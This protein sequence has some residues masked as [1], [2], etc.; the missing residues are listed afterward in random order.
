MFCFGTSWVLLAVL[1]KMGRLTW[2]GG[3]IGSM[4]ASAFLFVFL[5]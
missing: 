3:I 4:L 1:G 2:A 5:C